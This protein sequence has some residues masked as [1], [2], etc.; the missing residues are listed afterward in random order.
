MNWDEYSDEKTLDDDDIPHFMTFYNQNEL[1]ED[2]SLIVLIYF[3]FT[4]LTTVGFGDLTPKS[5]AER[6][7]MAFA[8]LIGVSIFSYY[9]GELIEMIN[10]GKD[11]SDT[12]ADN[13][14]KFF[15]MLRNFNHNQ[16]IDFNFK[17]DIEKYFEYRWD[18]NI[19]RFFNSD[20]PS[21]FMN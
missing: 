4:T 3:S 15:G 9:M 11:D 2:E 16:D 10:S 21:D 6:F 20:D 13:L 7:Y 12:E 18:N 17:R 5:D 1:S 19:S 8:M 14:A